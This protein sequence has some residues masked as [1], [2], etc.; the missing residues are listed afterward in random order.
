MKTGWHHT[1]ETKNKMSMNHADVSGKNNPRYG[2][3]HSKEAKQKIRMAHLGKKHTEETKL[4]L[5]KLMKGRIPWNTGK[6]LSEEHRKN[7]SLN[8]ADISGKNHPLYG[9]HHS[10]ESKMKMSKAHK[11]KLL[12]EETRK[13][14]SETHK[15]MIF[16]KEH[17]RKLS[18]ALKGIHRS[19][20][21]KDKMRNEKSPHWKGDN[22]KYF[23]LH[24][25]IRKNKPKV[26]RCET[27]NEK[28]PLEIANISGEYKRDINDFQW[29]CRKCHQISDGRYEILKNDLKK[30]GR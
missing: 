25:W 10:D 16:S 26:E 14:M 19:E 6:S 15:G 5:S 11:G 9:K 18:V 21:T 24:K 20:E 4:K 17:R 7:I 29:L 3:H 12:P 23:A 8:H 13:K 22:V 30:F 27:C 1:E 2:K 28:K